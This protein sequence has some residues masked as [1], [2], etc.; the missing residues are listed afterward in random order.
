MTKGLPLGV[1]FSGGTIVIL[2]FDQA[3][4]DSATV[5]ARARAGAARRG[6]NAVVQRYGDAAQR[7]VMVR[8][9]SV[10]A[11]GGGRR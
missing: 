11:G 4:P 2:Q 6:Q 5:R 1:E 8:V 7:Q 10:G 9:P 3:P